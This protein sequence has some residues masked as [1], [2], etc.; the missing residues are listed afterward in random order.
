MRQE[1]SKLTT[2]H[3]HRAGSPCVH[4]SQILLGIELGANTPSKHVFTDP[5][6]GGIADGDVPFLANEEVIPRCVPL[7]FHF[8]HY[9]RT[10]KC[11]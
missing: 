4:D 10:V 11:S 1:Q 7:V 2:A 6:K 9:L 3:L 5:Q 8:E